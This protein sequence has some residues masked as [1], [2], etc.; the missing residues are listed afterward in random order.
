MESPFVHLLHTLHDLMPV[1]ECLLTDVI[2][3]ET[4]I[5][6]PEPLLKEEVVG[7]SQVIVF[8]IGDL[9]RKLGSI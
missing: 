8:V 2:P 3:N 7:G 4:L 9:Q 6:L 1:D 5:F